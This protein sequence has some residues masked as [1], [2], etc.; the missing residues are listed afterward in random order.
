MLNRIVRNGPI[1]WWPIL[2]NKL[3]PIYIKQGWSLLSCWNDL[4]CN[5]HQTYS[6]ISVIHSMPKQY[7]RRTIFTKCVNYW[8]FILFIWKAV[9]VTWLG[10][11]GN[12]KIST[13]H[14]W[15]AF[16]DCSSCCHPPLGMHFSLTLSLSHCYWHHSCYNCYYC[17]SYNHV[18]K[19]HK[20]TRVGTLW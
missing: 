6:A 17:T 10:R 1:L 3:I 8:D 18:N 7:C 20:P 11:W 9:S 13:K 2:N 12:K 16:W 5:L 19:C 15:E 14:V 4:I